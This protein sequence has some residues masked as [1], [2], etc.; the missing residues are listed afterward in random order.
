MVKLQKNVILLCCM[1]V[2][3]FMVSLDVSIVNI[4]YPYLSRFFGVSI[5]NISNLAIFYLLS[6]CSMLIIFGKISDSIGTSKVF[7]S[8]SI[9]FSFT[10]FFCAISGTFY[11]ILIGRFFQGVASSMIS[12]TTGALILQRLPK[13]YIGRSFAA[14]TGLGGMGFAF[15]PPIGSFLIERFGWHSIFLINVPIGFSVFLF[16]LFSLSKVD[17]TK[18]K[19]KFD[20]V[21]YFLIFTVISLLITILYLQRTVT[22]KG[23]LFSIWFVWF[24]LLT[25]F[26]YYEKNNKNPTIDF[27]IFKNKNISFALISSFLIVFLFD[28]FNFVIPFFAIGAMHF[29][30]ELTG[31]LIGISSLITILTVPIIG[32]LSDR[33]GYRKMCIFSS[34][35][36]LISCVLFFFIQNF[37]FMLYFVI[38]IVFAGVGLVGFFVASPSLI[39]GHVKKAQSGF[40]SS[41]IQV[42][43]NLGALIG[44]Y[45]FS[46]FYGKIDMSYSVDLLEKGF[47]NASAFGVFLSI[48]VT[49]FSFLAFEKGKKEI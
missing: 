47:H 23:L 19:N 22:G 48:I 16:T 24:L 49:I 40:V 6:L 1:C 28:G 27:L 17:E 14:V 10:S 45:L 26:I 44:I 7:L 35:N 33:F 2:A 34:L 5:E 38:A 42:V 25:F 30:Q 13:E 8:G 37:S 36:L 20:L 9:L 12:A 18:L 29:S 43:Q 31:I 21:G 32:L 46:N 3:S 15:G 41:F 11:V 39:L 4:S